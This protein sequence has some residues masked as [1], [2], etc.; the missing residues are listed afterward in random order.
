MTRSR[1]LLLISSALFIILFTS[2]YQPEPIFAL[3][4]QECLLVVTKP[5]EGYRDTNYFYNEI[6]SD[7][8]GRLTSVDI[9]AI[10]PS[11]NESTLTVPATV[12]ITLFKQ[13]LVED[14]DVPNDVAVERQR[15][16][17]RPWN[18]GNQENHP[19]SYVVPVWVVGKTNE[20]IETR[21]WIIQ[22]VRRTYAGDTPDLI[23]VPFTEFE[24][25][26]GAPFDQK[27]ENC[28]P[29]M[30]GAPPHQELP[31]EE[32]MA[33]PK[34]LN[35][36]GY[37]K[38]GEG[39]RV[40]IIDIH[41][42]EFNS[43]FPIN[44]D[45]SDGNR[46]VAYSNATDLVVNSGA[47]IQL[48][49]DGQPLQTSTGSSTLTANDHGV[50]MTQIIHQMAPQ[51]SIFVAIISTN[52]PQTFVDAVAALIDAEVDIIVSAVNFF[53]PDPTPYYLAVQAAI[54]ARILWINSAGNFGAGYLR[55]E[56]TPDD[57]P[58]RFSYSNVYTD[59][60]TYPDLRVPVDIDSANMNIILRW[61]IFS[62]LQDNG[63]QVESTSDF[64]LEISNLS[65]SLNQG[66]TRDKIQES[67]TF[68]VSGS[69]A[70]GTPIPEEAID[71]LLF[72]QIDLLQRALDEG[73][74]S[75]T[76]FLG[77]RTGLPL[78]T[79]ID[80]LLYRSD[81]ADGRPDNELYISVTTRDASIAFAGTPLELFVQWALPI[82][83][84]PDFVANS[85]FRS[86]DSVVLVPGNMQN[87]LTVGAFTA[88]NANFSSPLLSDGTERPHTFYSDS[89]VLA[90]YSSRSNSLQYLQDET[91]TLPDGSE[92]SIRAQWIAKP[93]ITT[94]G[95]INVTLDD[96][97]NFSFFGTS[98]STA[99]IGGAAA[100][101][102]SHYQDQGID[103]QTLRNYLVT[104]IVCLQ[105]GAVRQTLG[106]LRLPDPVTDPSAVAFPEC[107][108]YIT[109][110]DWQLDQSGEIEFGDKESAL[111]LFPITTAE[112]FTPHE[113]RVENK[114]IS[115]QIT[116]RAF[117]NRE[118]TGYIIEIALRASEDWQILNPDEGNLIPVVG[119]RCE[120][121]RSEN[122]LRPA[123]SR[124]EQILAEIKGDLLPDGIY[125]LRLSVCNADNNLENEDIIS[126]AITFATGAELIITS[127]I[128]GTQITEELIIT[129]TAN[130]QSE[131][132]FGGYAIQIIPQDSADGI[133]LYPE[134]LN[135]SRRNGDLCADSDFPEPATFIRVSGSED[136]QT[137]LSVSDLQHAGD[138]ILRVR[139]CI[140]NLDGSRQTLLLQDV[141][142]TLEVP[143]VQIAFTSFAEREDGSAEIIGDAFLTEDVFR[144]YIVES[145]EDGA[146]NW[147]HLSGPAGTGGG[148]EDL[149]QRCARMPFQE[150]GAL[151][152][153]P[154]N[155][156]TI[157]VTQPLPLAGYNFRLTLCGTSPGIQYEIFDTQQLGIVDISPGSGEDLPNPEVVAQPNGENPLQ[158]RSSRSPN[159]D[160]VATIPGSTVL[161]ET[162]ELVVKEIDATSSMVRI[163]ARDGS[164]S[165]WVE[166]SSISLTIAGESIG[167]A[168]DGRPTDMPVA[169]NQLYYASDESG[170]W[171]IYRSLLNNSVNEVLT[172]IGN[173]EFPSLS[174]RGDVV[175]FASDRDSNQEIYIMGIDG[176]NQRNLTNNGASD[177]RPVWSPD[178]SRIL[179]EST[180]GGLRNL[181]VLDVATGTSRQI[182][183]DNTIPCCGS[184]SPDGTR[185][186]YAANFDGAYDIHVANADGTGI[187]RLTDFNRDALYPVWQPSGNSV[188]FQSD[189]NG[190]MQI[191]TVRANGGDIQQLTSEG[192]NFNPSWTRDSAQLVFSSN[193]G[194]E[195]AI[196][197]MN[198][199]GRNQ[200]LLFD[201]SGSEV[202]PET[203]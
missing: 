51:A 73:I 69:L 22:T 66:R 178:G 105:D 14:P 146:V 128:D 123:N 175:A 3:L 64:D 183:A 29:V 41:F 104:S 136:D 70:D 80:R 132:L 195:T 120:Q 161:T 179:F 93:D 24:T 56:Y 15:F 155:N 16:R 156:Q 185:I 4:R 71:S 79:P 62:E 87:V 141:P 139:L 166:R 180:R 134:S 186:A 170:S 124:S 167:P 159:A 191:Y 133:V 10:G 85:P 203:R 82:E 94:Y 25:Q 198:R 84:D 48:T 92:Q 23:L 68:Q 18:E 190:T 101:V 49:P 47:V 119:D 109:E 144:F 35:L 196:Y 126:N 9:E 77:D 27:L 50:R 137:L 45:D 192:T 34:A 125:K 189:N 53:D 110:E 157:A 88:D 102:A 44:P 52:E 130:I 148:T 89:E 181:Y 201:D 31:L 164:I 193:R 32:L 122:L 30:W 40:G 91:I 59:S 5:F 96:G 194:G 67:A 152:T 135:G 99:I 165:G 171:Q 75:W 12:G 65:Y 151:G 63:T 33:D 36:A 153:R 42:Q 114:A 118:N 158:V 127:P 98:A 149:N 150:V 76:E 202:A 106:R 199:D 138:F 90:W 174:P 74:G 154:V 145:Q 13:E 58:H 19:N 163:E 21:H 172:N 7:L 6:T 11:A 169:P 187:I 116:G 37:D 38:Q 117:S 78:S 103:D 142:L 188:A 28:N 200:R 43:I 168:P 113:L 111:E 147:T 112:L 115:T 81:A 173:N 72:E 160:V 55:Q 57:N 2:F 177:Y 143:G 107:A 8:V 46:A 95:D 131:E 184:W 162:Q 86:L 108:G 182:T 60:Q 100:L 197:I 61:E 83:F 121:A 176:G 20:A 97:S 54:D 129:G 39:V 140:N 1:P 26:F 17:L